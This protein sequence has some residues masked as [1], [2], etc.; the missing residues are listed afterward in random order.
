LVLALEL[1]ILDNASCHTSK[2]FHSRLKKWA[3]RRLYVYHLPP[4]SPELNA[5]ERLWKKIKHHLLPPAA[6]EQ[7]TTLLHT[8]T[9][10]LNTIGEVFYL[11][12]LQKYTE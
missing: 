11:P 8:L 3:E 7:F 5:I 10:T 4:Y 9:D 1:L 2:A 6:W 12:S